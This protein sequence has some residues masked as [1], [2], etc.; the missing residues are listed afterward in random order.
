MNYSWD[1]NEFITGDNLESLGEYIF[2]VG[3]YLSGDHGRP[4]LGLPEQVII[5]KHIDKINQQK[6]KTLYCYGHDIERLLKNIEKIDHKFVLITHNSDIGIE[7]EYMALANNEKI[8]KWFGQNNHL[9]HP[10]TITLPIAIARKKYPHGDV[11]LLSKYSKPTPKTIL[12]YKNF[13]LGSNLIERSYI[14][15]V[16]ASKGIHM[17]A[18][19]DHETYLENTAKSYFSISPPGNGIDCHRIWECLYLK[20]VPIVRYHHAFEQ[21][22]DLPILFINSWDDISLEFLAE[23]KEMIES[24]NVKHQRLEFKYWQSLINEYKS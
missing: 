23:K 8:K 18:T 17:A 20:T 3:N 4:F 14:N 16:T 22:K 5:D 2:D 13:S 9:L 10:K 15:D 11:A 7:K 24:F 12:V 6:P 19:C 21:F 1:E